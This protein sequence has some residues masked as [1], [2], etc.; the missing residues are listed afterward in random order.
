VGVRGRRPERQVT[1]DP[2]RENTPVQRG[3][4]RVGSSTKG[5]AGTDTGPGRGQV[6]AMCGLDGIG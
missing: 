6:S 4:A 5:H 2:A 3:G 1:S